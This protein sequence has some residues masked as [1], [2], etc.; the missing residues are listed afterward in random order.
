MPVDRKIVVKTLA[1]ILKK[2]TLT[3]NLNLKR[4]RKTNGRTHRKNKTLLAVHKKT[5][6]IH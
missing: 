1:L 5:T 4:D 6:T 3:K 2:T